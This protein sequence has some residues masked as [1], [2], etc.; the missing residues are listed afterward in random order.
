MRWGPPTLGGG[1]SLEELGAVVGKLV[2]FLNQTHS[3]SSR[4]TPP[5]T[6]SRLIWLLSLP[7]FFSQGTC[8]RAAEKRLGEAWEV[9]L[10]VA[11]NLQ[12]KSVT[13]WSGVI[14]CH[15]TDAQPPQ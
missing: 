12:G 1:V 15:S 7:Q 2:S 3:L 6:N 9:A 13:G 4:G 5:P 10:I 14:G 8:Y 11:P